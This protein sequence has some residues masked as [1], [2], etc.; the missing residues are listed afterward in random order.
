MIFTDEQINEIESLSAVNYTIKQVAMYL[1]IPLLELRNEYD[2]P[3]SKFKY[4]YDRGQLIAQAQIDMSNLE[5][6]K[7]GNITAQQRY[8]KRAYQNKINQAKER[9]FHRS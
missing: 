5:S 7:K 6:A 8:D 2:N 1:N 4:H 9:I 3:Q